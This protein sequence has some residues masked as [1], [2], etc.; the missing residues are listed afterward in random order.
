MLRL[1]SLD[2]LLLH[3][4]QD[5]TDAEGQVLNALPRMIQAASHPDLRYLLEDHRLQTESQIARL[6]HVSLLL[7]ASL[8]GGKCPGGH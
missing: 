1:A 8:K 2:D 7:G 4:L 6:E 3:G 5:M